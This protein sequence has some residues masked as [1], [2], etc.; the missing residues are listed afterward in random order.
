LVTPRNGELLIAA[1]QDFL[2]GGYLLS[3]KDTFLDYTQACQLAGSLLA[4]T[5][6]HMQIHLPTPCILKPRRLWSGKQICSLIFRPNRKCPV[7]ANL[8]AKGKAYTK[9]RELC[10]KDSYVL[11]RNSELIAGTLDKTHLGS[12]SKGSNI[13]YV[14]L[15]DFGQDYAIKSMWRLAKLTS[16]YLINTGFSIGVG[17]VTPSRS[18][19]RR[20][21]NLLDEGYSKCDGYIR[22]MAEGRLP[23]QPGCTVEETLEAVILKELSVIREHAGQACLAELHPTN[24][25]LTMALSG[26]KGSFINISQMIACVGQQALN[27][28]RVPDGFENRSL[29]HFEHHSKTPEAKGFVENSFFTG[30]TPTEF[31]FHTMGGREGLVDTAVKTAETGY[32]QR[33]LVKSLEDLV[34]HY[35]GSVRNA[36][37]DIVQ[38][39]Y[40]CDSLDP[41][42][43][44][45]K[46]CPVDFERV[47]RHVQARCPYRDEIA[48]NGHQI[49][50]A[51]KTFLETDALNECS[52]EFR[53]ELTD[54]MDKIADRMEAI[55]KKFGDHDVVKEIE[56][57][58]CS[59]LVTFLQTCGQKYIRAIIEPGTAVGALAAQSI[60]EPGTQMT[61]KTFHF[62]GVASMNITQGVPR[63]K[64]I[65]N[66]SKHISTPIITASLTDPRDIGFAR[67]VKAR[68]ER[69]TLGEVASFIDEI[70]TQYDS[71]LL[72]QLNYDRIKLLRLEISAETVRYSICTSKLK[73]K[74]TEVRVESETIITVHPSGNKHSMRYNFSLNELKAKIPSVVVKGLPTVN[75]AVIAKEAKGGDTVYNL[76]VEGDNLR[77]VIATYGVQGT[78][79]VSNNIIEV[80]NTLGIEAA[81]FVPSGLFFV[82]DLNNCRETI[83]SEIK[84]VMENHGMSVDYRHIMLLAA[85]MTHT[86]EVLGITRYGLSKM[87]QSILN[88]ASFEKTA[89]HLFD[90]AYY[91]Q[92]D[93]INGV[94]ENIIMGMPAPIG[95]GIFKLLH[96]PMHVEENPQ[97]EPLLFETAIAE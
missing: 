41:T 53:T 65:I 44:E 25:P 80:A 95:T 33:R 81:R 91:G 39:N 96:K 55:E 90:A 38:V 56:R 68:I 62:A 4:D 93:K 47:L 88:L 52:P 23:T 73:L 76:C 18:L 58:T 13:F 12:G 3:K 77:E 78:K 75:R 45:G 60:G 35:D 42:Y 36:E 1:T 17:D 54:F 82:F 21:Q 11:I 72:I 46:D 10:V 24:S 9:N 85:Q 48:L 34:V 26:S 97:S 87:K 57:L 63:I 40:G 43:M 32:M 6:T 69:T 79:T 8:E 20:K 50:R 37:G 92:T 16:F 67:E 31:F 51:T 49:R 19:L 15:R 64:E 29:P 66:A 83:M 70:Y 7:K 86:G 74:P 14:I 22:Q 94:S 5:D 61:L 30:L 71:F 89:D 59:Q 27:G 2:T 28:K 84:M